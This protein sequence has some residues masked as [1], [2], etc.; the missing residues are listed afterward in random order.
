MRPAVTF[1]HEHTTA[2]AVE[3]D[4]EIM[5]TKFG[6][7]TTTA[8][9]YIASLFAAMNVIYERDLR[10]RLVQ[11]TTY[12]RTAPDPWTV[13]GSCGMPITTVGTMYSGKRSPANCRTAVE[14]S[15][16]GVST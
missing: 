14:C 3:T 9:N 7:N 15:G 6:N 10:I 8:T 11:G 2:I 5:A 4:N 1:E 13:T 16:P 12:L